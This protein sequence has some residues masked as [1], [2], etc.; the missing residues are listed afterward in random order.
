[1]LITENE[2]WTWNVNKQN[3]DCFNILFILFYESNN[4]INTLDIFTWFP[5]SI[6]FPFVIWEIDVGFVRTAT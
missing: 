2:Q 6:M 4:W 1:M 5:T 3:L